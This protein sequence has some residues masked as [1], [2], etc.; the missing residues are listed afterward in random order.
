MPAPPAAAVTLAPGQSATFSWADSGG[1][2]AASTD[3][4]LFANASD[5]AEIDFAEPSAVSHD[6]VHGSALGVDFGV[7]SLAFKSDDETQ[8]DDLWDSLAQEACL[9]WQ[10]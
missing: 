3:N 8:A 2:S 5:P 9:H 7:P 6:V 4:A 1:A 10:E